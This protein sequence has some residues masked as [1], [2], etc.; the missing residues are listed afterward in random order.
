[1]SDGKVTTWY[2]TPEELEAYKK[3]HPISKP[4]SELNKAKRWKRL[5]K[6]MYNK[7]RRE[8]FTDLQICTRINGMTLDILEKSKKRWGVE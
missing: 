8:G 5:S 4:I 2:M 6:E 7:Y 1:M 3:K